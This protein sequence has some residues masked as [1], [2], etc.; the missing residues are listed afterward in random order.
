M[1]SSGLDVQSIA[2]SGANALNGMLGFDVDLFV[3][4]TTF[5]FGAGFVPA[6]RIVPEQH[7]VG[8]A[9]FTYIVR[10]DGERTAAELI[11]QLD[12]HPRV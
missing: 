11:K 7:A 9:Q 4:F 6:V 10:D 2:M 3:Q 8:L 1:A 12:R 5:N